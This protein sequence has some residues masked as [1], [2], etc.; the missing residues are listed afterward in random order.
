MSNT[1][2]VYLKDWSYDGPDRVKLIYSDEETLLVS[3]KDFNRA[4]GAI[5]NAYKEDVVRDFAIKA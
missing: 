2:R 3:R 4:F 1:E 5:I